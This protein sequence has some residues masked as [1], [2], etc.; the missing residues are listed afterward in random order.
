MHLVKAN[1]QVHGLHSLHRWHHLCKQ[2]V[3]E[4]WRC[5]SFPK[6]TSKKTNPRKDISRAAYVEINTHFVCSRS[7]SVGLQLLWQ[8]WF[9]QGW[10]GRTCEPFQRGTWISVGSCSTVPSASVPGGQLMFCGNKPRHAH[11]LCCYHEPE[12][13]R[14]PDSS[15]QYQ[16]QF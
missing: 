5:P 3:T 8:C 4:V 10:W 14:V 12:I 16:G 6:V 2:T 15:A 11:V 7:L 9:V 1:N 13:T